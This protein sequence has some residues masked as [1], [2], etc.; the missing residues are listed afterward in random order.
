[1][2]ATRPSAPPGR[3]ISAASDLPL[4]LVLSSV[5]WHLTR[6]CVIYLF[7]CVCLSLPLGSM[8]L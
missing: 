4:C 7:T 8:L 1:M 6:L 3:V 5:L 2:I